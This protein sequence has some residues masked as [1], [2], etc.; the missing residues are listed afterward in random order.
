MLNF[1]RGF[2]YAARYTWPCSQSWFCL[3]SWL[4]SLK[5]QDPRP[6]TADSHVRT[7]SAGP[8]DPGQSVYAW[9]KA[10][11]QT[12]GGFLQGEARELHIFL[13]LSF[14]PEGRSPVGNRRWD[15]SCQEGEPGICTSSLT[16]CHRSNLLLTL[17]FCPLSSLA[18][19]TCCWRL[20]CFRTEAPFPIRDQPSTL[21]MYMISFKTLSFSVACF[22]NLFVLFHVYK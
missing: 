12:R 10:S 19:P 17:V 16:W 20:H 5:E 4:S 14:L 3:V 11:E 1:K 2:L 15:L 8:P 9:G 21:T 18:L 13:L 7:L 22:R 6:L